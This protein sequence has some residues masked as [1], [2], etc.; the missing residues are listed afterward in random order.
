MLDARLKKVG[1]EKVVWAG[2]LYNY[3]DGSVEKKYQQMHEEVLTPL[4]EPQFQQ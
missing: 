3:D 4:L 1:V 2:V